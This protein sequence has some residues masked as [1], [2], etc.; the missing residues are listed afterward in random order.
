LRRLSECADKGAPHPIRIA[1]P[2]KLRDAF[3][4]LTGG[5]H[6]L[7]RHFETQSLDCGCEARRNL[8]DRDRTG[9]IQ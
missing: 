7:A 2:T 5:L 1:K 6:P 8:K 3:D 9:R 4:R